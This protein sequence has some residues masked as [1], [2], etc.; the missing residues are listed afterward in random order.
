[1]QVDQGLNTIW[2]SCNGAAHLYAV[3]RTTHAI[4]TYTPP[5]VIGAM[6]LDTVHGKLWLCEAGGTFRICH[7]DTTTHAFSTPIVRTD[8]M[9]CVIDTVRDFAYSAEPTPGLIHVVNGA[10]EAVTTWPMTNGNCQLFI[11]PA[12]CSLWWL[13]WTTSTLHK[14]HMISGYSES[15][16]LV[17]PLSA[18]AAPGSGRFYC[19]LGPTPR[20]LQCIMP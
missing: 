13:D 6:A 4:T 9:P 16:P 1:V 14:L 12:A 17:G 11:D 19:G 5:Y 18:T 15:I 8:D 10:T 7:F 3:N 20:G 2:V